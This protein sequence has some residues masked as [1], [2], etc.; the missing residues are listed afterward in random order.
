MATLDRTI[1]DLSNGHY[2]LTLGKLFNSNDRAFS[3]RDQSNHV[4]EPPPGVPPRP[5]PN[6]PPSP[7]IIPV[8]DPDPNSPPDEPPPDVRDPPQAPEE[9]PEWVT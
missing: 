5:S 1:N 7:D 2:G 6:E 8:D 3:E 4:P 9:P